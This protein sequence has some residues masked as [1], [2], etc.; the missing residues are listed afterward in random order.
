MPLLAAICLSYAHAFARNSFRGRTGVLRCTQI[1]VGRDKMD[2]I[3]GVPHKLLA[4][5]RL[6]RD[7]PEWRDAV[8]LVQIALPTAPS[9]SGTDDRAGGTGGGGG[10]SSFAIGRSAVADQRRLE[11]QVA[12]IVARI[13]SQYGSLSFTPVQIIH[14][15]FCDRTKRTKNERT[16]TDGGRPEVFLL[17]FDRALVQLQ[18]IEWTEMYAL[19]SMADLCLVTSIRDGMNLTSHEF[20]ACQQERMSPIILSEF[21]GTAGCFSS[22]IQVNPWN[23]QVRT[24]GCATRTSIGDGAIR[25]RLQQAGAALGH[26][27]ERARA[28]LLPS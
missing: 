3:R 11:L 19:L 7:Y 17:M 6:L 23:Y 22:A 10:S 25:H 13:N 2:Y 18:A 8:V 14:V 1:I 28:G 5:E 21:A 4:F 24:C 26:Q 15:T 9:P 20:V 16:A 12:E 27:S